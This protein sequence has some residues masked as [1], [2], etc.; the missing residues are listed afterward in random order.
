MR[1]STKLKNL[2]QLYSATFDLDDDGNFRLTLVDKRNY[3][4]Q[5]FI[6]KAYSSVLSKA[7]SHMLKEIKTKKEE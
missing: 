7:F 3:D 2:L 1:N 6:D 4:T 5:L